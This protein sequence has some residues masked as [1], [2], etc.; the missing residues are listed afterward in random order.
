L[1][2]APGGGLRTFFTPAPTD[3]T[4][5]FDF[6]LVRRT[7]TQTFEFGVS[8][9]TSTVQYEVQLCNFVSTGPPPGLAQF[10]GIP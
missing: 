3:F 10:P 1:P 6:S 2:R 5:A 7:V 4:G 9:A 8:G